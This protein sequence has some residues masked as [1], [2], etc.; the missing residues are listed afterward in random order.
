MVAEKKHHVFFHLQKE[1]EFFDNIA[2]LLAYSKTT[3]GYMI[4]DASG[5]IAAACVALNWG[6]YFQ[7]TLEN[8]KG[9]FKMVA[10]LKLTDQILFP[11]LI[12]GEVNAVE[13]LLKGIAYQYRKQ[14]KVQ[15]ILMNTFPGDPYYKIKKSIIFDEYLFLIICNSVPLLE[16]FK[17]KSLGE[18]GNV[19]LFIEIPLM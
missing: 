18:D 4:P 10:N 11:Y 8:P 9:F 6:D 16:D 3:R 12:C 7:L 2:K 13:T 5:G 19:K 14:H 15:L 1:E 17:Q